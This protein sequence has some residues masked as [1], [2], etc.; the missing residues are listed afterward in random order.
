MF[1]SPKLDYYYT[2]YD[3]GIIFREIGDKNGSSPG[4]NMFFKTR[5]NLKSHLEANS[6]WTPK[7]YNQTFIVPIKD[8]LTF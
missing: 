2:D 6:D 4:E 8:S 5:Y 7:R 1:W 3:W